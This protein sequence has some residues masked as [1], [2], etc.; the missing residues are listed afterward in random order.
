MLTDVGKVRPHNEDSLAY[1]LARSDNEIG[2]GETMARGALAVVADGMGG[3]AAGEVA[4]RLAIE[5]LFDVYYRTPGTIP[6]ALGAAF[7]AANQAIRDRAEA[8]P[9]CA[10]MGT[11][12]TAVAVVGNRLWLAHIGDSR[13]YLVREGKARQISVDHSLVN[14]MF[15]RGLITAEERDTHPDRNVIVKALG[16]HPVVAPDIWPHPG[17]LSPGDVVVLCSDGLSDLVD[18]DAIA[19]AAALPPAVA[20][21]RLCDAALAA[22]GHDNISVGVFSLS[23]AAALDAGA[24]VTRPHSIPVTGPHPP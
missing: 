9:A 3:H 10:G 2:G 11:T 19:A 14:E 16:T 18:D 21:R 24:R 1:R 23:A 20:C 6:E 22:G 17:R 12:C 4:S 15:A 5:A 7:A 13:C 8:D